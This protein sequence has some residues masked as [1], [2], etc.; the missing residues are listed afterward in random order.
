LFQYKH[1]SLKANKADFN[2]LCLGLSF[3]LLGIGGDH[4][5]HVVCTADQGR[6]FDLN[7]LKK[8]QDL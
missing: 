5:Y 1:K 2:N 3:A 8:N 6:I 7:V 4:N